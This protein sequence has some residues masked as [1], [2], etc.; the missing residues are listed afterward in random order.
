VLRACQGFALLGDVSVVQQ[1]IGIGH[2]L[3]KTDPVADGHVAAFA[4]QFTSHPAVAVDEATITP[5][6]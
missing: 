1:C 3:A 6:L 4:R 5:G 2:E